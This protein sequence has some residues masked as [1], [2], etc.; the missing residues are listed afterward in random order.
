VFKKHNGIN[1]Y[2][3][4]GGHDEDYAA[5]YARAVLACNFDKFPFSLPVK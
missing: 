2:L 5:I 1:Y 3:T 4:L